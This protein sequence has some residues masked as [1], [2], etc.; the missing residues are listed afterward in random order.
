MQLPNEDDMEI[1]SN[2]NGTAYKF[3]NGLMI[4]TQKFEVSIS[5]FST[6]GSLYTK[7]VEDD[8]IPNFPVAF[9][10]IPTVTRSIRGVSN[11]NAWISS[12]L[13]SESTTKSGAFDVMRPTQITNTITLEI[14][15]IAIGKWK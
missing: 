7:S 5:N 12:N 6:W 1:V 14:S 3:K 4:V 8:S 15:V 11:G 2:S 10:E 13:A 9:S